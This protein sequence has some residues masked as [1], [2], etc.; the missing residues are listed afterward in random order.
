MAVSYFKYRLKKLGIIL[1]HEFHELN[2]SANN[3]KE[4]HF[5]TEIS[6]IF[7]NLFKSFNNLQNNICMICIDLNDFSPQATQK[8]D[9]LN[10]YWLTPN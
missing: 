9:S 7:S 5:V 2:E 8:D 4:C 6:Q 3:I 10:S 1:N